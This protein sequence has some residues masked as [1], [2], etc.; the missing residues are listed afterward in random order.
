VTI[1]IYDVRKFSGVEVLNTLKGHRDI[2]RFPLERVL[3]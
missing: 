1:C 2:L 3:A